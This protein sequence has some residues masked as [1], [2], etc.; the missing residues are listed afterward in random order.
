MNNYVPDEMVIKSCYYSILTFP[1][2]TK[3]PIYPWFDRSFPQLLDARLLPAILERLANTPLRL[4]AKLANLPAGLLTLNPMGKWSVQEHIGHLLD[5]E[6]LW[7]GRWVDITHGAV[8][9]READLSNRAT[10]EASHN[11]S[12][13]AALL[14]EFEQ[15]RQ[16]SIVQ[17]RQFRAK[18][19]EMSSLHPR[20][21]QPLNVAGLAF[22]VAEHDD[23]HL[24]YMSRIIERHRG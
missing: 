18:D 19:L 2:M 17:L 21:E 13:L 1:F 9:M 24:A 6:P 4:R 10:Q 8:T 3:P 12:S 11:N 23:H 7:Q 14:D 16:A 15:A 22:F 20:L 5:L